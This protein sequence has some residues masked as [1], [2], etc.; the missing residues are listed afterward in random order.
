MSD[1]RLRLARALSLC[2]RHVLLWKKTA[3]PCAH[4]FHRTKSPQVAAFADLARELDVWVLAGSQ[5]LA[6]EDLAAVN[7]SLVFA[8]DGT[9]VARYDKIHMFDVTLPNGEVHARS[10]SYAGTKA[11]MVEVDGVRVGLSICYDMRFPAMYRALA[12][13]RALVVCAQCVHQSDRRS[14]LACAVART[15][16]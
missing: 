10:Q 9:I 16:H 7:R 6:D 2:P 1:W 14:A 15:C 13:A 12:R 8:P 5:F 4:A 3:P 11:H